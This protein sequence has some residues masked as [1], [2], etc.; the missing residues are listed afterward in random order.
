MNETLAQRLAEVQQQIKLAAE[1]AGRRADEI[2]LIP[3]SKTHPVSTLR[4]AM[5]AGITV[6]GENKVQ[7]A[8]GKILEIGGGKIEWH[9]IGHL[10]S[11]KARKAVKLFDVIQTVDSIELAER[12]ER[13]CEEEGRSELKIFIQVDLGSEDTK[14]GVSEADLPKLVEFINDC[15]SLKLLGLMQVPPF[16]EEVEKVR[17]F[18]KR[19]REIRDELLPKGKLSMGMSHDFTIAIEEG[20]THIR[21]GTAIFGE[22]NYQR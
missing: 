10:Q 3:V 2:T 1:N 7:E 20:A 4:E 19:L 18:F 5:E 22:R 16:F 21:V 13:I 14:S 6:F 11:N 9:L 8:E 17:P 12:L 15:K